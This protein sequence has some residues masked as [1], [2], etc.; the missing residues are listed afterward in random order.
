MIR[1]SCEAFDLARQYLK[2]QSRSL[3]RALFE[4]R[5]ED[6]A[7]S[8]VTEA[9]ASFQNPDGGFGLALEPDVRT[10]SSSALATG[11][12]LSILKEVRQPA[13]DP[14]VVNAVE[15]LRRTFDQERQ[16][17]RAV[18]E[19]VN[20]HPHAPWWHDEDGSLARTFDDFLVMPR[21]QLVALLHHYRELV[22]ADWLD[23][24]TEAT[25]ADIETAEDG[26]F[27]GGGDALGYALTLAETDAVPQ[28]HTDRILP[29]LR[30]QTE[31]VVCTEP[32]EWDTYCATP[33]KVAPSPES[34]VTDLLWEDLQT[35]LDY[36]IERQ[37]DQGA[38]EPTWTW[39]G[40]YP[41]AWEKARREWR[42]HVTL[43]TLTSLEAYERIDR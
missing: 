21:A 20:D 26:V 11:I 24:L 41:E 10:P 16:V 1:L 17:W 7:V 3:D 22:P 42:G 12:G 19:D 2:T 6:A 9:L 25:V 4:Y 27:A 5:F 8:R 31:P 37:T 35:N 23:N 13:H 18:P 40:A 30:A 38:W 15:Y 33:L 32:T 28:P 43:E 34:P 36:V 14:M 39:G 29:R